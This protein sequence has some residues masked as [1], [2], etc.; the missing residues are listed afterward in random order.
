MT[1]QINTRTITTARPVA[2]HPFRTLF[3]AFFGI[4]AL[5][6][7]LL[8]ILVVWANQTL[9]NTQLFVTTFAPLA[10]QSNVQQFIAEKAATTLLEQAPPED[11]ATALLPA[12]SII[13]QTS[14]QLQAQLRPVITRDILQL[15][16]QPQFAELWKQT[17]QSTHAQIVSQLN[18]NADTISLDLRP[19]IQGALNQLQASDLHTVADTVKLEDNAGVVAL[20]GDAIHRIR[21]YYQWFQEGTI[22]LVLLTAA[23]AGLCVW[24]SVHHLKTLRRILVGMGIIALLIAAGLQVPDFVMSSA[25]AVQQKA[26]GA[27]AHTLFHNLQLACIVIG[28]GCI[29]GAIISKAISMLRARRTRAPI[30]KLLR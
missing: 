14:E 20:N 8:S 1:N 21:Q 27:I 4:V 11:I 13:G 2:H 19:A 24:I 26:A 9:T 10:S 3:A 18:S 7:V 25:D 17:L 15:L 22:V 6:L 12:S 23:A 29:G 30:P 28:I 16:E 5:L